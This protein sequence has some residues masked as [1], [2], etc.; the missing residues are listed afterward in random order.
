MISVSPIAT[1]SFYVSVHFVFPYSTVSILH[2]QQWNKNCT[3]VLTLCLSAFV[4]AI[5]LA[6]LGIVTLLILRIASQ[7]DRRTQL[8]NKTT[9]YGRRWSSLYDTLNETRLSFLVLLLVMIVAKAA[10]VFV[11]SIL[12]I[13][14]TTDYRMDF[15]GFGQKSGMVQVIALLILETFMIISQSLFEK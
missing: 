11:H 6:N 14:K 2:L 4:F 7:P 1:F 13:W 12:H 8:F 10:V 9:T 5:T 3:S 15:R